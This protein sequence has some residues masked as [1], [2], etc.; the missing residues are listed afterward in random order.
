M[1]P[2]RIL[3]E[4]EDEGDDDCGREEEG[5]VEDLFCL[6]DES[7]DSAAEAEGEQEEGGE[8]EDLWELLEF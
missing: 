8:G 4:I 7:G 6:N 2:W 5:E 1:F 3:D